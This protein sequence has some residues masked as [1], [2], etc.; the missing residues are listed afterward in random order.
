MIALCPRLRRSQFSRRPRLPRDGKE[1]RW[2]DA[3]DPTVVGAQM[4]STRARKSLYATTFGHA[5]DLFS[6]RGI[7]SHCVLCDLPRDQCIHGLQK[8]QARKAAYTAKRKTKKEEAKK[9]QSKSSRGAAKSRARTCSR[10]HTLR[11]Y[12]RY[13]VCLP[14]GIKL[15]FSLCRSCGRYFKPDADTSRSKPRCKTCLGPRRPRSVWVVASAG[16]QGVGK[17]R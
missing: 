15:G 10:C 6:G 14:C 4:S 1:R 16:S 9:K 8:A 11:C 17:R 7:I 12:G 2:T 3:R 5:P 13:G